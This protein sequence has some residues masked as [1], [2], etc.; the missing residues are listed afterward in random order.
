MNNATHSRAYEILVQN[1]ERELDRWRTHP[2]FG[3][4]QEPDFQVRERLYL[5]MRVMLFLSKS[6]RAWLQE[7]LKSTKSSDFSRH[8]NDHFDEEQNHEEELREDIQEIF[9]RVEEI[10][11]ANLHEVGE[12]FIEKM[13][14]ASDREKLIL[15][16]LVTESAASYFYQVVSPNLSLPT[17]HFREHAAADAEHCKHGIELLQG[18]FGE[19][20]MQLLNLQSQ[21]WEK[22]HKFFERTLELL[23]QA[24]I[25]T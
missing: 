6:T 8:F 20:C 23:T 9:G 3:Y 11:D 15:G 5:F 16:N 18:V 25:S 2:F 21:G 1:N 17:K 12:W 7:R 13:Q 19:E 10:Y 22:L 14:M 4:V 24:K